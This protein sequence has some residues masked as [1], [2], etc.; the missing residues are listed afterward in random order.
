MTYH[1]ATKFLL[2]SP[3]ALPEAT[4]GNRLRR[5]FAILSDP[6][7]KLTYFRVVGNSGK[8][9]CAQMLASIF[10]HTDYTVGVLTM[11]ICD[12]I[13]EN[14][15]IDH[16]PLSME[17]MSELI[18]QVYSQI[19]EY[20]KTAEQT[21]EELL[22]L[23]KYEILLCAAILAF[24]RHRCKLC[25]IE[26]GNLPQDPTR[27]LPAPIAAA[28]CGTIPSDDPQKVAQIRSYLC[29]GTREIVSA[30]QDQNA[31]HV[32]S[33]SCAAINCRLTLPSRAELEVSKCSL[34]GSEF[35]YRG[36]DYK[37]ALCGRFQITNAIVTLEIVNVLSR[38]GIS[39]SD[40]AVAAG[41]QSLKLPCKLELLSISPTILADSTYS[42]E[43]IDTVC[44]SLAEFKDQ[45]GSHVCLCL[46]DAELAERYKNALFTYGFSVKDVRLHDET[47]RPRDTVSYLRA[48]TDK[49]SF[50]LI[51]GHHPFTAKLR[52][53]LLQSMGF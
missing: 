24:S 21:N 34:G 25:V 12:D 10:R 38:H 7:K 39:L 27:F 11:P 4:S 5:F 2:S 52:Y 35:R 18:G 46:P 40:T 32:I 19:K 16:A 23:T 50:W 26:S 8:T 33:Q 17:E 53:E 37:I 49:D 9:V 48:H 42:S 30:P 20:N 3:D 6:Q 13:R 14:I 51:S 41:L 1:N 47:A 29:H 31:Y 45:I 22:V 28:I 15:R 36:K 44:A 43:S